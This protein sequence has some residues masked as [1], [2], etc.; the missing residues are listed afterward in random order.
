L[1]IL[2]LEHTRDIGVLKAMG[3]KISSIRLIFVYASLYIVFY[4]LLWGNALALSL[5]YIL[6]NIWHLSFA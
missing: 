6:K 4:G 2:I 5:I 3:S 1:L